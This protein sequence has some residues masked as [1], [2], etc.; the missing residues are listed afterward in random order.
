MSIPIPVSVRDLNEV[1]QSLQ[2]LEINRRTAPLNNAAAASAPTATDDY[3]Q[4]YSPLSLWVITGGDVYMCTDATKNN[5]VWLNL[6]SGGFV[7][8]GYAYKQINCPAGDNVV[9]VSPADILTLLAGSTKIS[10]TGS[11]GAVNSDTISFDVVQANIDHGSIGGLSDDDHAQY[12]LIDGT[13]AMSGSLDM[14][15]NDIQGIGVLKGDDDVTVLELV[16]AA[17]NTNYIQMQAGTTGN[18]GAAGS[19]NVVIIAPGTG[20]DTNCDLAL[21][22]KGTGRVHITEIKGGV[23]GSVTISDLLV[24]SNGINNTGTVSSDTFDTLTATVLKITTGASDQLRFEQS[25]VGAN[26]VIWDF[27]ALSADRTITIPDA[28]LTLAAVDAT[29]VDAAGAVMNTDFAAKGDL[30]SATGASTPSILS[31]GTNGQVVV[32]DSAQ[33]KGVK[34]SASPITRTASFSYVD[35]AASNEYHMGSIPVN[36][37]VTECYAICNGGTSVVFTV[38]M[39]ARSAPF[40]AGTAIVSAQTA[41]TTG[42]TKTVA[43]STLTADNVLRLST[44]TVTGTVTEL[45]VIL[46]YTVD[47]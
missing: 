10:I 30:L 3:T 1:R 15:S 20:G 32:A 19:G 23:T 39:R 7:G 46:K 27:S 11:N 5:A 47:A 36:A 18:F 45:I 12:L 17:G 9:S 8:A 26:D 4:G 6:S 25:A 31:V 24:T 29:N 41:T 21:T 2:V 35:P 13:R 44:G 33:A 16:D 22:G 37:T 43:S 14:G 38:T 40:S 42:A 34:W 28:S